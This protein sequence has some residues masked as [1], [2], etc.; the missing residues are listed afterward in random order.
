MKSV[1]SSKLSKGGNGRLLL[2][3]QLH[4]ARWWYHFSTLGGPEK[5]VISLRPSVM[6]L[7]GEVDQDK[8]DLQVNGFSSETSCFL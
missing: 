1:K 7:F 4:K 2:L 3:I 5:E 8:S 6:T